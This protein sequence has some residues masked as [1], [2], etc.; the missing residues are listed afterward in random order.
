MGVCYINDDIEINLISNNDLE[1]NILRV[2]NTK[3]IFS[4][5]YESEI[6]GKKVVFEKIDTIDNLPIVTIDFIREGKLFTCEAVFVES[7]EN[8]LEIN[9]DNLIF[10]RDINNQKNNIK[11]LNET[12]NEELSTGD[13]K[14]ETKL[15]IQH[16]YDEKIKEYENKKFIFLE[17]LE[18]QFNLKIDNFKNDI[19]KKLDLFIDK[20]DKKKEEILNEEIE[21]VSEKLNSKFNFVRR[22]DCNN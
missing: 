3:E 11:N 2:N 14:T 15:Q 6:N 9:E 10:L 18:Q 17:D 22:K 21:E 4:E 20:L 7:D 12:V 8:S 13:I 5:V 1:K 16:T 19:E